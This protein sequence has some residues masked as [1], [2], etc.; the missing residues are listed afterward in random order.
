MVRPR[1]YFESAF[2]GRKR[3]LEELLQ[4][5]ALTIERHGRIILISGEDGL[6]KTRLVTHFL[7]SLSERVPITKLTGQ[8]LEDSG[9]PYYPFIEA[10]NAYFELHTT[11]KETA[12]TQKTDNKPNFKEKRCFWITLK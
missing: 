5:L 1:I 2:V 11:K 6:G 12:R 4:S 7:G 3:E 10:F 8:C 9:K